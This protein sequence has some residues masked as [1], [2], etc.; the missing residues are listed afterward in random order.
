MTETTRQTTTR[1][2]PV[3]GV[4]YVEAAVAKANKRAAK[5][6]VEPFVLTVGEPFKVK[7]GEN[8]LGPKFRLD[9]E[10]EIAGSTPKLNGW[11][12]VAVVEAVGD[13]YLVREVPGT[14][15]DLARI[16][17][18]IGDDARQCDHCS[19]RRNRKETFICYNEEAD[20]LT[21]IGRTCVADF[22]GGKSPEALALAWAT[23]GEF[24]FEDGDPGFYGNPWARDLFELLDAVYRLVKVEG[25]VTRGSAR[26]R[27]CPATCDDAADYL[28]RSCRF[29]NEADRAALDAVV[30]DGPEIARAIEWAAALGD[31]NGYELNVGVLAR[32]GFVSSAKHYGFAGS[33]LTSYRRQ[34]ARD[35]EKAAEAATRDGFLKNATP[36]EHFGEFKPNKKGEEKGVRAE[37]TFM[38]LALIDV[39]SM[40]GSSTLHKLVDADGNLATWFNSGQ[41]LQTEF[42]EEPVESFQKRYNAAMIR[43]ND[44]IRVKAT[45]KRHEEYKGEA[46]TSLSRVALVER[47]EVAS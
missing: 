45:P 21:I 3:W 11:E 32:A 18:T 1:T 7:V 29:K 12:L 47:V 4:D 41:H 6:G 16:V 20:S 39:E 33:I 43:V 42:D 26:E 10:I 15:I 22:L 36:S 8:E 23:L 13:E 19:T 35:A 37:F 38:V 14:G 27:G 40:Y 2:L 31:K 9:V 34:V 24:G 5:L 28:T 46:Q 44:V 25:W 30:V 17:A